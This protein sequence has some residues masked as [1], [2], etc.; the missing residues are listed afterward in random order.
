M[1]GNDDG[2]KIPLESGLPVGNSYK[3]IWF[4]RYGQEHVFILYFIVAGKG[5]FQV[6]MYKYRSVF[7]V[8]KS[9]WCRFFTEVHF[10]DAVL[11]RCILYRGA[12]CIERCIFHCFVILYRGEF[13]RERL[14]A[15]CYFF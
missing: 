2:V 8:Y 12:F 3:I 11:Q 5:C 15:W 1:L 4:M 14:G 7:Y 9:R 10:E 6:Y 13:F